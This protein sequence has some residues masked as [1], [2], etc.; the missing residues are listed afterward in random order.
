[1]QRWDSSPAKDSS[2]I[3]RGLGDPT[4]SAKYKPTEHKG[5]L[6][7]SVFMCV[8]VYGNEHKS[9]AHKLTCGG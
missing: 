9:H 7:F 6:S 5:A 4:N 2:R 8:L 3:Y 1:M